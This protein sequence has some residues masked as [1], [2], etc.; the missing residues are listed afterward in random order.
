MGI[1]ACS[2]S[3]RDPMAYFGA[4]D[5]VSEMMTDG[6]SRGGSGHDRRAAQ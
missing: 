3:T 5:F 6:F 2:V 1:Q 4:I